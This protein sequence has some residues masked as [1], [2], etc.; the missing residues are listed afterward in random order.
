MLRSQWFF[1]ESWALSYITCNQNCFFKQMPVT[2]F[3]SHLFF[4]TDNL[5]III[6]Q[7]FIVV[8]MCQKPSMNVQ[9]SKPSNYYNWLLWILWK[10]S[11]SNKYHFQFKKKKKW[12]RRC[13][14]KASK[15]LDAIFTQ[16]LLSRCNLIP[17]PI[18]I[19]RARGN[20][21]INE[22]QDCETVTTKLWK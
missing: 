9:K 20:F 12:L 2:I 10:G 6:N 18:K 14:W 21:T 7:F 16:E 11:E 5:S 13:L 1:Y 17:A 8:Y 19:K 22:V 3:L 15:R 4:P